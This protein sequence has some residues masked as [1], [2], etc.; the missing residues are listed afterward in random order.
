MK[1]KM[2]CC[3]LVLSLLLEGCSAI[4]P[5]SKTQ[6]DNSVADSSELAGQDGAQDTSQQ[7]SSAFDW[8]AYQKTISKKR[9]P[10]KECISTYADQYKQLQQNKQK[11]LDFSKCRFEPMDY[12]K[13]ISVLQIESVDVDAQKSMQTIKD[14]LKD[15]HVT[16]IDL[17]KVLRD[18]SGQYPSDD[19]KEDSIEYWPLVADHYP[20]FNTG[21]GF[22]IHTDQCAIQ[23]GSGIHMMSDGTICRYLGDKKASADVY[24]AE[25]PAD[26]CAV[27]TV[28]QLK[29][30]SWETL[31]GKMTVAEGA[32]VARRYFEEDR[33]FPVA[34]GITVDVPEVIVFKL[35]D[36]FG[37]DFMVRRRYE[38]IPFSYGDYGAGEDHGGYEVY[39][40]YKH[41]YVVNDQTVSAFYG[42]SEAEQMKKLCKDQ[43]SMLNLSQAVSILQSSMAS[44][45]EM[46]VDNV[47]FVYCPCVF[48]EGD[49][50]DYYV[51]PCW[52]FQGKNMVNNE[53][54]HLY[55]DALTGAVYIFGTMKGAEEE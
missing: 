3:C 33:Y 29:N 2:I 9:T 27:G 41:A 48:G 4:N 20:D 12:V 8:K 17:D 42:W 54:L 31:S 55:V 50:C 49:E 22:F 36:K 45:L 51:F 46:K 21:Q 7:S 44:K 38:N 11:M 34:E 16:D 30:K 39:M 43:S 10:I 19:S 5:Y 47:S 14:W 24:R 18:A 6:G 32:E 25:E 13:N 35:K 40:E 1:R 26:Q 28:E 23:M 15:I 53:Y 52:E 37:Y